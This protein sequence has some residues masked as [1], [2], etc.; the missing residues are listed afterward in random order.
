[1]PGKSRA[2]RRASIS[3]SNWSARRPRRR[4]SSDRLW[5]FSHPSEQSYLI[6]S[7]ANGQQ[8]FQI[9]DA[10]LRVVYRIGLTD[11]RRG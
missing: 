4:Q 9:A 1:M 2:K 5:T 6:A 10:D 7:E 8:T 3:S 11:R